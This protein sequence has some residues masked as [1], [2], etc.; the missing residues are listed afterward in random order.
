MTG[1]GRGRS[2]QGDIKPLDE[3]EVSVDETWLIKEIMR[4]SIQ[5][6]GCETTSPNEN[7]TEDVSFTLIHHIVSKQ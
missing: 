1:G 7:N 5:G 3:E 4:L 6:G 2:K